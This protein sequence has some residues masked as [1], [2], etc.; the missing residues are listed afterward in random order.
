[1]TSNTHGFILLSRDLLTNSLWREGSPDLLKLWIYLLLR[2]N[3]SDRTF[4]YGGVEVKRGQFLRS[5]RQ[6]GIDCECKIQNKLVR[7][8]PTKIRRLLVV[9]ERDGR[10]KILR[11]DT[12]NLGTLIEVLNWDSRQKIATFYRGEG[13]AEGKK[14][15]KKSPQVDDH[16]RELWGVWLSELSPEAPHP[17]LTVKRSQVL[18]ALYAEHLQRN[19]TDP[20]DVFRG[21]CQVLK[22]S[23]FHGKKRRYQMPESFLQSPERRERWYLESLEKK[24]VQ[25]GGV[26]LHWSVDD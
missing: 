26:D 19:G 9:L 23:D 13:V 24:P 18:N 20:L 1:M 7:W 16:S 10:I 15:K 21:I 3:H 6:I 5:L 22:R 14:S 4:E 17:T 25:S 2:C 12:P 11:H 8:P